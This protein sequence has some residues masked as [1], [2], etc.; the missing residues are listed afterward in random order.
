MIEK[1]VG[2]VMIPCR[3]IDLKKDDIYRCVEKGLSGHFVF[4][5]EDARMAPTKKKVGG[6]IKAGKT[7]A[8]VKTSLLCMKSLTRREE[9]P[10]K[11]HH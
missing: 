10:T 5:T 9:P 1:L 6:V 3:V 4:A 8:R 2:G 7:M 11:T